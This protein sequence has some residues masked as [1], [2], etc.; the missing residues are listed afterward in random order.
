MVLFVLLKYIIQ[1]KYLR[2]L[3]HIF[4][5]QICLGAA[6]LY[7]FRVCW[8]NHKRLTPI[9]LLKEI[10][11]VSARVFGKK[12]KKVCTYNNWLNGQAKA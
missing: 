11:R 8:G 12:F 1:R 5:N 7:L 6:I 2:Q 10:D 3:T 4:Q 9:D